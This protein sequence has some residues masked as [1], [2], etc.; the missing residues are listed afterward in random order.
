MALGSY[1]VRPVERETGDHSVGGLDRLEVKMSSRTHSLQPVIH[2]LDE[3]ASGAI[4]PAKI[5]GTEQGVLMCG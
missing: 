1:I 5:F 4:G 2:D 3:P